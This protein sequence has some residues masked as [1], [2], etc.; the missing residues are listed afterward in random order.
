MWD[1]ERQPCWNS[2]LA[3]RVRGACEDAFLSEAGGQVSDAGVS[4]TPLVQ[5]R[6]SQDSRAR[7]RVAPR[8]RVNG[9]AGSLK[10]REIVSAEV[11]S[12]SATRRAATTPRHIC[13]TRLAVV[14]HARH[15]KGSLVRARRLAFR[16]FVLP[17]GHGARSSTHRADRQR[18]DRRNYGGDDGRRRASRTMR[19]SHGAARR[20]FR[21]HRRLS[22]DVSRRSVRRPSHRRIA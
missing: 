1:D 4:P 2:V 6:P 21:R 9:S 22:S 15:Q 7:A 8:H 3:V 11:D 12:T 17:A 19:L 20:I 18:T 14:W 10:L 13:S 5:S 16:F